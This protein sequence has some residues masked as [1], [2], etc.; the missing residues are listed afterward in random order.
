MANMDRANGLKELFYSSCLDSPPWVDDMIKRIQK[1]QERQFTKMLFDVPKYE[2]STIDLSPEGWA[3]KVYLSGDYIKP[4][5]IVKL[6]KETNKM[7]AKKCDRCGKLYEQNEDRPSVRFK[8]KEVY[9]AEDLNEAAIAK[10]QL[11]EVHIKAYST[12]LDL[13]PECKESFKKWW[14]SDDKK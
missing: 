12:E 7:E 1:E 5:C 3:H 9:G 14:E 2:I 10:R 4:I 13:C 11:Q 6:E 8:F